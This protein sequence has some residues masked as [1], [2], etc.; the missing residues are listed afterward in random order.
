MCICL[1][2]QSGS[3]HH[4]MIGVQLLSQLVCEMNQVSEVSSQGCICLDK[5]ESLLLSPAIQHVHSFK[6]H[7]LFPVVFK[8]CCRN[9]IIPYNT[10]LNMIILYQ[11]II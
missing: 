7:F 1:Y 2:F 5:P 6:K 4:V 10:V 11:I 3:T 9:L 8:F